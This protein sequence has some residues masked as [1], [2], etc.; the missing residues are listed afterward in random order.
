MIVCLRGTACDHQ[1]MAHIRAGDSDAA[2]RV[3][4]QVEALAGR[5]QY[6]SIELPDGAVIPGLQSVEHLRA[7]LNRFALPQDLTGRRVLDIG[8]W[9]GWFSFEMERRGADVVAVDIVQRPAFETASRALGSRVQFVLAD[10]YQLT[11]ERIGRFDV[12]LFLGVLYHLKHPLLALE[13]VCALTTD[14][15]CI[16]SF[17]TDDGSDPAAPPA[18]EFYE[19]GELV[20]RYDNWSGPNTSCLLAFCRTAGFATVDLR[21]VVDQRAHV[22]CSRR[23]PEAPASAL[24]ASPRITGVANPRT[25][26]AVFDSRFDEY[27]SIFF[28]SNEPA[29]TRATVMPE[30]GGYGVAPVSVAGT[31]QDGWQADCVLPPGT[32]PGRCAVRVRTSGSAFSEPVVVQ[33]DIMEG[34][35]APDEPAGP[36]EIAIVADGHSWQRNQ[37]TARPGACVSLWVAGL[38][39]L[40]SKQRVR[41]SIGSVEAPVLFVSAPWPDGTCQVNA[42]LPDELPCAEHTIT[43]GYGD[44]SSPPAPLRIVPAET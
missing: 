35:A 4:E 13:R 6:H 42:Q 39:P 36:L 41:V 30:V 23:W 24:C 25:G 16:E 18:M 20:G 8:A 40:A 17:V 44:V 2:E 21:G 32:S 3:A 38:P 10:V 19:T 34:Y 31:G 26:E 27:V 5:Q 15:A 9:D 29:L 7:R 37:V 43:A 22:L 14:I 1:F 12:V 33:V 28:K 11:P